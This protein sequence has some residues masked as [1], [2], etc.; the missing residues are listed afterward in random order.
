M[1]KVLFCVLFLSASEGLFTTVSRGR[2]PGMFGQLETACI[3]CTRY[4]PHD[5]LGHALALLSGTPYLII[6]SQALV[7]LHICF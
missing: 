4:E 2:D 1:T 5:G 3:D 7:S 6:F